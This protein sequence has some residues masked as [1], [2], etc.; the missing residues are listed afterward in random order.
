MGL[1]DS[2]FGRRQAAST[3]LSLTFTLDNAGYVYDDGNVGLEPTTL[4]LTERRV[5][6][7]GLNGSGKTTLLKLLDGALTASSG[8]VT[9]SGDDEVLNPSIKK[10]NTRIMQLVGRVRREEIPNAY[11]KADH[12]SA[13][14]DADMKKRHI[15]ETERQAIIGDLFA[16]FGL[17]EIARQPVSSLDSEKRHLLAVVAALAMSP[18]AIVADEPTKGLD[19]NGTATVARA[20]FGY[21]TQVVFATHDTDMIMRPEYAIDRVLVLDNHRI[22]FDG[23]PAD[24]VDFY[25]DLI[26]RVYE[27][28]RD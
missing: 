2:L 24:A 15:P 16:H 28:S 18:A 17:S 10:Q 6:V 25:N 22:A 9:I 26:R 11:Y 3:P 8:L 12:V 13:A 19:E 1:F 20:L 21:N 7:I 27:A 4:T 5:A 23:T 14:V